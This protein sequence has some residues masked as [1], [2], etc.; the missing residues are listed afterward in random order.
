MRS[1]TNQGRAALD[2]IKFRSLKL[3]ATI[4]ALARKA[5]LES[6]DRRST[7]RV[8][9]WKFNP[10]LQKRADSKRQTRG[11]APRLSCILSPLNLT[12]GKETQSLDLALLAPSSMASSPRGRVLMLGFASSIT[13]PSFGSTIFGPSLMLG[14]K[15][16]RLI[17]VV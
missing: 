13:S 1:W 11:Y 10:W 16:P 2:T 15:M 12:L 4:S 14:A 17:E 7:E 8:W 3:H 5:D 6:W 9:S